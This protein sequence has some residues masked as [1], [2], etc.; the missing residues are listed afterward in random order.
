MSFL[1]PPPKFAATYVDVADGTV[2]PAVGYKLYTYVAGTSTPKDSYINA[3]LTANTNPV[4][5]NAR[6]EC[7]L[8]LSGNYKL[9][10]TTDA[11]V[12][13]WTVDNVND[14]TSNGTFAAPTLTGAVTVTSTAVTWSGNPTHSGNHTW[15]GNQV[16]N[17]NVTVG[18]AAADTL[19]VATNA[20][21]WSGNPTHSGNHTW[22][23]AIS[24]GYTFTSFTPG[25]TF[26][27][28]A[29]GVS[30]NPNREGQY[31]TVG[32]MVLFQLRMRLSSKGSST[33]TA[34]I[35]GL[36]VAMRSSNVSVA[37]CAVDAIGMTGLTGSMVASCSTSSTS[38]S[39]VQWGATGLAVITDAAFT[40]TSD[41]Y[42]SG[43]YPIT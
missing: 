20:V 24:G 18:D 9:I 10:L 43:I 11:D 33:G 36:P 1:S 21:T 6:G 17:G 40:N 22:S 42:V 13:V 26:G 15:N 32:K 29:V 35:T 31:I 41:I 37:P 5:L 25:V 23:G 38:I 4:I 34:L 3:A 16:F 28:A 12:T 19:T 27:G 2:K 30:Y 7:D 8:V 14:L 39:L